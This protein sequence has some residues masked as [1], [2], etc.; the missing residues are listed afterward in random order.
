MLP[1]KSKYKIAKRLGASLFEKTQTQKFALSEAR[2][3]NVKRK[4]R[5]RGMSDYGKQLLE[6]QR[7]RFTYGLSER[8]LSNYAKQAFTQNDPATELHR[9]LELR[10]DSAIYRAGL[11]S[12]RRAARQIVSHGH[13]LINGRRTTVPSHHLRKGDKVAIRERSRTSPLF[14][15]LLEAKQEGGSRSVPQWLNVDLSSLTAEVVN[16]PA[17]NPI[18]TGL[19]YSTVFEYYSR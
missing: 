17:Y 16:E 10:I 15:G 4:G 19:D 5:G 6:K 18:E 14:A 2:S 8:Q 13:I 9:E 7:V 12:S 3:K 1:I 11:A